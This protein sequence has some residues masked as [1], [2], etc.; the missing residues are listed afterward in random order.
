MMGKNIFIRVLLNDV[1]VIVL[2]L[3]RWTKTKCSRGLPG[4]VDGIEGNVA[5]GIPISVILA[6]LNQMEL[7][8]LSSHHSP[9][10][11]KTGKPHLLSAEQTVGAG[12]CLS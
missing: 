10:F 9:L 6:P 12:Q 4:R 11:H 1:I 7:S 2:F 3:T 5:G 8:I